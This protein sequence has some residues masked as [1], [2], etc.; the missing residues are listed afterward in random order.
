MGTKGTHLKKDLMKQ[1][2]NGQIV[3][4]TTASHNCGEMFWINEYPNLLYLNSKHVGKSKVE[5][6]LWINQVKN[7]VKPVA[8]WLIFTLIN[9]TKC[10]FS[11]IN[12]Y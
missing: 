4:W 7:L 12:F 2:K 10:S 3:R 5:Y 1:F 8:Y 11:I 6:L 9:G